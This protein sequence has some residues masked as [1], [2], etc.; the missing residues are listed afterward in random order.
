[1][2]SKQQGFPLWFWHCRFLFDITI[3]RAKIRDICQWIFIA[4]V[5]PRQGR[6]VTCKRAKTKL[7]WV[8]GASMSNLSNGQR[9]EAQWAAEQC[10]EIGGMMF[11]RS[12]FLPPQAS[13]Q[14]ASGEVWTDWRILQQLMLMQFVNKGSTECCTRLPGSLV[15]SVAQKVHIARL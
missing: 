10:L 3:V 4:K 14:A 9:W 15:L 13:R 2:A 1:M 8:F 11:E 5:I 6:K 7:V 12:E